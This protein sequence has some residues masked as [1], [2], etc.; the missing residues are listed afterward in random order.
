M[1]AGG[2]RGEQALLSALAAGSSVEAAAKAAGIS[3]RTVYRRLQSPSFQGHLAALRDEL[4]TGALGELVGSAS[5]A[6]AT[7]KRLLDA[8]DERVQ[9]GAARALLDQLLRLRE[10]VLLEQRIRA[11][12]RNVELAKRRGRR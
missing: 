4:V 7:L 8:R 5:E 3:E 12:E 1:K 9:L 11:L 6:V 2:T 10:T